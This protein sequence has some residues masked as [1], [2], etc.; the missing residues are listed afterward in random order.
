MDWELD[1]DTDLL[2]PLDEAAVSAVLAL[3][4][5]TPEFEGAFWGLFGGCDLPGSPPN[6]WVW[7]AHLPQSLALRRLR[8][9][10]LRRWISGAYK[11]LSAGPVRAVRPMAMLLS[12]DGA[13]PPDPV[14]CKAA[15]IA[16]ILTPRL[17]RP[18]PMSAWSAGRA[19]G[20]LLSAFARRT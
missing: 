20:I 10:A 4:P 13:W 3:E 16:A 11:A 18:N 12:M 5:G 8:L 1:A 2:R 9:L 7:L 17:A 14:Q 19:R 15:G 6:Q